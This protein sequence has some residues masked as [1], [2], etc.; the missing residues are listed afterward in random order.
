MRRAIKIAL[1]IA[2]GGL[3]LAWAMGTYVAAEYSRPGLQLGIGAGNVHIGRLP[4]EAGTGGWSWSRVTAPSGGTFRPIWTA[5]F[6]EFIRAEDVADSAV[7]FAQDG[8]GW[9][10]DWHL[11]CAS[12]SS[13][14]LTT[15]FFGLSLESWRLRS[16]GRTSRPT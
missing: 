8:A 9:G 2:C 13:I 10:V 14:C 7:V 11:G 5:G 16:F 1:G 4:I 6:E 15:F 12:P 3:V